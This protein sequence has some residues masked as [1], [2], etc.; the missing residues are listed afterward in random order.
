M[1]LEAIEQ[2]KPKEHQRSVLPPAILIGANGRMV[3]LT[4]KE[5]E[6]AR[7]ELLDHL[8]WRSMIHLN[9]ETEAPPRLSAGTKR[10]EQ[11]PFY[12]GDIRRCGPEGEP[13]GLQ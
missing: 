3:Q 9:P 4:V 13:L 8:F 5:F 10:C 11:C 1:A 2:R 6:Q 12:R 7:T